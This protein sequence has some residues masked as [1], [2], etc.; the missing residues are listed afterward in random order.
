MSYVLYVVGYL[1]VIGGLIYGAAVLSLA[2]FAAE[3]GR[4]FPVT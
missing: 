2:V 4:L 3:L 1:I